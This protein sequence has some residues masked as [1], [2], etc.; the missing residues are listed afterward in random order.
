VGFDFIETLGI[1]VTEGR[2]FSR[3]LRP[4]RQIVFNE[5]AIRRMGIKDPVGKTI[6]LWGEEKQIVGV[7]KDFNFESLY[8]DIKPCFL[9]VL[10]ELPNAIVKVKAGTEKASLEQLEKLYQRFSPGLPFEYRFLDDDYQAL[11]I[12]EQRVGILSRYFASLAILISCL[13]LLGLALFTAERRIKEIGI[14]KVLGASVAGIAGLLSKEFLKPVLLA[15]SIAVPVAHYLSSQWLQGFA[16]RVDL[17]WWVLI[18]SGLIA[19]TVALMTISLQ[20]IKA[21]MVSPAKNLRSE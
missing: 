12:A 1:E 17:E 3:D 2:T 13:G 16:Y 6:Q 19:T 8:S 14:R 9:Q 20:V 4:E 5:E 11:Y 18:A 7:V 15:V 21:A 10:P